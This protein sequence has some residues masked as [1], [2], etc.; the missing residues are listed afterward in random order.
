MNR[1]QR[2]V[3]PFYTVTKQIYFLSFGSKVMSRSTGI[4]FNDEMYDFSSPHMTNGFGI[5][6]SPNN[7]IQP[8]EAA[9]QW[10][11]L[12]EITYRLIFQVYIIHLS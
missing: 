9:T 6:P 2:T 5:P 11:C 4:I 3:W 12:H 8:G 1:S 10:L 7:F